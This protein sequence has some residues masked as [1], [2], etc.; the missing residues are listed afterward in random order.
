MNAIG[1]LTITRWT[2]PLPCRSTWVEKYAMRL[3]LVADAAEADRCQWSETGVA[4]EMAEEEQR[5]RD[6]RRVDHA[7]GDVVT[8]VLP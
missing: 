8:I 6:R 4:P 7:R 2:M 1:R 5:R 3:R